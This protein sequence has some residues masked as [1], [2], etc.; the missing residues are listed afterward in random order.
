MQTSFPWNKLNLYRQKVVLFSLFGFLLLSLPAYSQ[1]PARS[2]ENLPEYDERLLSYG[3]TLGVHSSALRLRFADQFTKNGEIANIVA[4]NG[5][6][7]SIGFL[8]N[9]RLAQ[10]LDVRLMPKVG[11]YQYS[12]DYQFTDPDIEA[13]NFFADF[14]TIDLP[15]MMKY[16]SQ[17]RGNYRMVYVGGVTPT[18]DVTGKKQ[19]QENEE[20]GLR[21]KGDNLALELGFGTDVYF[22]LFKFSP[23]IRYSYGLINV[24]SNNQNEVGQNFRRMGTQSISLYLIFN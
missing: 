16:K 9:L 22:P 21:L 1:N 2:R 8:T 15:L 13:E 6:G 20:E 5:G 23:E 4:R 10:Y 12:I 17:R 24:L 7:F 3:F 19:R 11:F 18:I 14:T